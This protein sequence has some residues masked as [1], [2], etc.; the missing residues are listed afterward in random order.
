MENWR[1]ELMEKWNSI[2]LQSS[3]RLATH[4]QVESSNEAHTTDWIWVDG[5]S[6][7]H[8]HESNTNTPILIRNTKHSHRWRTVREMWTNWFVWLVIAL[9]ECSADVHCS[10][11]QT[12][13]SDELTDVTNWNSMW[14]E[15]I[16]CV[17]HM[18][19]KCWGYWKI[20]LIGWILIT[21]LC[22]ILESRIIRE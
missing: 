12:I 15:S 4:S 11:E 22:R 16:I 10:T 5:I 19:Q 17:T 2:P 14:T 1:S 21:H 9:I 13:P 8:Q 7:V 20:I 18:Y 6:T 3:S